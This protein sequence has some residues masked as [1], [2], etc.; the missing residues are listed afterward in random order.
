VAVRIA[1]DANRYVD[2][3]WGEADAVERIPLL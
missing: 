3:A 2:F 1:I